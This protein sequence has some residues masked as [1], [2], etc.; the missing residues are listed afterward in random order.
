MLKN[1]RNTLPKKGSV[2]VFSLIILSFML[3]SAL[4]IATVSVVERQSASTTERSSRSFQ[5]ADSGAEQIL[6]AI[7]KNIPLQLSG[8]AP[9]GGGCDNGILSGSIKAGTY[10]VG[11]YRVSLYD[12]AG[13]QL[14]HCSDTAWR[15]EVV[16][17][18]SEGSSGNTTRAVEIG[19]K[20]PA[21]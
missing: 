9:S 17:L 18:R 19:V 10:L 8:L 16:K 15:N 3:I 21:L 13:N 1:I 2:L 6:R 20:A 4:S 7:Y 5:V 12:A 11:T 14:N